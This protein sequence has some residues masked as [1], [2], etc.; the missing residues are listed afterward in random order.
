MFPVS[1]NTSFLHTA[2]DT[3]YFIDAYYVLSPQP[4]RMRPPSQLST[5]LTPGLQGLRT[6]STTRGSL[7]QWVLSLQFTMHLAVC[8]QSAPYPRLL[9][10]EGTK[11]ILVLLSHTHPS[12]TH[13]C[14][15]MHPHAPTCTH[16]HTH[17]HTHQLQHG[18]GWW[19]RGCREVR[20]QVIRWTSSSGAL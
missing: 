1:V 9:S 12:L 11:L 10:K 17:T 18:C 20:E 2:C 19:E 16:T 3:L 4:S 14:T 5:G 8:V 6:S 13:K 7:N 15:H